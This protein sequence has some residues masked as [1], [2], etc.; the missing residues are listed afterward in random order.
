MRQR[1]VCTWPFPA[2]SVLSVSIS[3]FSVSFSPVSLVL[4][5]PSISRESRLSLTRAFSVV[6][7]QS[8]V[9]PQPPPVKLVEDAR[10]VCGASAALKKS[11]GHRPP[12]GT[13]NPVSPIFEFRPFSPGLASKAAPA[14]PRPNRQARGYLTPAAAASVS[15]T[16]EE[17]GSNATAPEPT[18]STSRSK[19]SRVKAR[20]RNPGSVGRFPGAIP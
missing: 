2:L 5:Q 8:T 13:G 15:A 7:C 14:L 10:G 11:L 6:N 17:T 9:A 4:C 3:F 19:S 12:F 16:S 20:H 1:A 18:A